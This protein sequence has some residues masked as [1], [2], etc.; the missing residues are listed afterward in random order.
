MTGVTL[1]FCCPLETENMGLLTRLKR[2]RS[3]LAQV[4][5]A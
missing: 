1:W 4:S 3:R 5:F 2:R